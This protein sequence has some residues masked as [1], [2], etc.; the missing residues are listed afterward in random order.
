MLYA[1][2]KNGIVENVII[3]DDVALIPK[4]SEGFDYFI[5]VDEMDPQ[6]GVLWLYD[7]EKFS[8]PVAPSEDS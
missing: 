3:L 6:P 7:G 4:F 8:P 1:Q 2:I 5:R